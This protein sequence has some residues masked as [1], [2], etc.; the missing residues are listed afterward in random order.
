MAFTL[1]DGVST[2]DTDYGTTLLDTDS[3][4]YWTLN[5]TGALVLQ[6]L[7]HG[8]TPGQAAKTLT[9]QYA[10]DADTASQDVQDLL[11]GLQ[12]AGLVREE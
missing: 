4:D 12:A 11:G 1:R 6:T 2:A 7:L 10:V 8:G 5:P 9:E 3:G